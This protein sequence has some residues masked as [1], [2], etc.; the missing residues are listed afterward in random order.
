MAQRLTT[1]AAPLESRAWF[2]YKAE[3]QEEFPTLLFLSPG[4]LQ[5]QAWFQVHIGI[6]RLARCACSP[7]TQ[8][9][10][11]RREPRDW[12]LGSPRGGAAPEPATP[13]TGLLPSH[14]AAHQATPSGESIHQ[15]R[16]QTPRAAGKSRQKDGQAVAGQGPLRTEFLRSTQVEGRRSKGPKCMCSG[17]RGGESQRR[18]LSAQTEGLGPSHTFPV[19]G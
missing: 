16:R 4:L 12:D 14:Q 5:S 17:G 2:S 13:H 6:R 8:S 19:P 7:P 3:P 9:H 18:P 11:Q 10:K 15:A 1:E